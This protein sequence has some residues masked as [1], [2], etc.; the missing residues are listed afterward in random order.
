M[1]TC[2]GVDILVYVFL[3]SALVGGEWSASRPDHFTTGERVAC[4]HWLGD[5]LD[6]RNNL[7]DVEKI[8]ILLL[9]GLELR[10]LGR[11]ALNLSLY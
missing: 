6:P 3:T 9:P 10:I 5:W 1:K 8:K 7:E 2:G 4:I 11:P